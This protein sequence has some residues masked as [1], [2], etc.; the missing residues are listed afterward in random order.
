MVYSHPQRIYLST[1]AHRL[2][3]GRVGVAFEGRNKNENACDSSF[4]K[5]HFKNISICKGVY[6]KDTDNDND[7]FGSRTMTQFVIR[8]WPIQS[9]VIFSDQSNFASPSRRTNQMFPFFYSKRELRRPF[10]ATNKTLSS[11]VAWY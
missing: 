3:D 11:T 7:C 8:F 10:R 4:C 5:T 2:F 9:F 1:K 6:C